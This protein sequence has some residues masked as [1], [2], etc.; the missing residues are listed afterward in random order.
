MFHSCGVMRWLIQH[1]N[2]VRN[3]CAT[4]LLLL[5]VYWHMLEVLDYG[6]LNLNLFK[7]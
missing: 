5:K 4:I 7:F 6:V 3:H 1:S 2:E